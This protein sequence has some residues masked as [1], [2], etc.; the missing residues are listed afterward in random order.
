MDFVRRHKID[1]FIFALALIARLVLFGIN[2]HAQ[3]GDLISTI[4]GDDGYYELSRSLVAGHGFTG[5]SAPP[6]IPNALRTPGY[7]VLLA[8][9]LWLTKSYWVTILVQIVIGAF[10]PILGRRIALKLFP[11]ARIGLWVGI[12]MALE[13]YLVLFSSIFYTETVFIFLFLLFVLATL[14]YL[15]KGSYRQL[16]FSA[17]LLGFAT[18][19]KTTTQY[20]PLIIIPL[21]FFR[22]RK[23]LKLKDNL[24]RAAVFLSLY[25]IVISPWLYRNVETFGVIGLSAQPAYNLYVYMVPSVLS[26][27]NGTSFPDELNKFTTEGESSGNV[28]T[29]TNSSVYTKK[30]LAILAAHPKGVLISAGITVVTFFTHDGMLTVLQHAGYVPRQYLSKPALTL[31]MSSPLQFLNVTAG[32]IESPFILVLLFRIFWIGITLFLFIGL[33]AYTRKNTSKEITWL[34]LL[35]IL[36]FVTTSIVGG[37]GVNARYRM[38]IDP[39]I[40]AFAIYGFLL[41][42]NAILRER[43]AQ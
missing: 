23:E 41:M 31:L 11:D 28:I 4:H 40:F 20:L 3:N 5:A 25:F 16:V 27:E 36:Y 39:L 21:F 30:A 32:Y 14:S 29:L 37:L 38:P 10:I 7:I 9:L 35:L 1:L 2:L 42:R 33:V 19:T 34:V 43:K 13:P 6:Y 12:L 26:L 18:L 17:V 15:E 8:G 22:F 24:L